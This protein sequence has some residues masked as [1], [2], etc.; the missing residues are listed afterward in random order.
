MTQNSLLVKDTVEIM[1]KISKDINSSEDLNILFNNY[2]VNLHN[3]KITITVSPLLNKININEIALKQQKPYIVNFLINIAQYY[4]VQDPIYL[5][6]LIEDTVDKDKDE[7]NAYSEI[8][9][10]NPSFVNGK[11]YSYEHFKQILTFYSEQRRDDSVFKIPW[12]KYIYFGSIRKTPV[13]CER[14]DKLTAS[15]LGLVFD[16]YSCEEIKSF[17]E[18]KKIIDSL[19]II[20]FNK[21]KPYPVKINI[22]YNNEHIKMI[23]DINYKKVEKLEY[24]PVY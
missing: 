5:T 12:K 23:Y 16:E 19:D 1:N 4:N 8:V 7:R 11:I 24:D 21:K 2:S 18:N 22:K 17:E 6:D 15:F 9:L 20:T 13:D 10:E 3:I 14:L